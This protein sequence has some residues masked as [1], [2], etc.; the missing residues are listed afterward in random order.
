MGSLCQKLQVDDGVRDIVGIWERW[1]FRLVPMVDHV[2]KDDFNNI[3][4]PTSSFGIWPCFSPIKERSLT[5]PFFKSGLSLWLFMTSKM[6]QKWWRVS[7]AMLYKVFI[8]HLCL[9]ESS[10]LDHSCY[11]VR[12]AQAVMW[13]G[14]CGELS[15]LAASPNWA[16]SQ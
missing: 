7:K 5:F 8:F 12:R 9:L 4:H 6:Q 14:P 3:S 10:F 11:A 13:K 1:C 16:P 2:T 15:L